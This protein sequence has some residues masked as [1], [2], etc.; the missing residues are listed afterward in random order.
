MGKLSFSSQ[1]GVCHCMSKDSRAEERETFLKER[2]S[3][4]KK[5]VVK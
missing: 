4:D 2:I 3:G 1:K 5:A